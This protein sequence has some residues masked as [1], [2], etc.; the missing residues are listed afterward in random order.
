MNC[1]LLLRITT[2]AC[3]DGNALTADTIDY[4]LTIKQTLNIT[5]ERR[6][7][8]EDAAPICGHVRRPGFHFELQYHQNRHS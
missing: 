3:N 1:A 6:P 8:R 4:L 7:D 2:R 5:K